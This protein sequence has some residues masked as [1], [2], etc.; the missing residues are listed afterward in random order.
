VRAPANPIIAGMHPDPSVCRARDGYYLACSSFEY[1]PGVPIHHSRDLV[2]WTL[3]GNALDRPAQLPLAGARSSGGIYAPTL[4]HHDGRFWLITTNVSA[5]GHVIYTAEDARGPW[6]DP[7]AVD[8][9][10][11]IDPDLAWDADG[12]CW[13]TYS[14]LGTAGFE[15]V[16]GAIKQV[17]L[18][19]VTG[20]VLESPRRLWSGTG[21]QFPEAP[22]L[23]EIDGTWYLLIA[24]GGTGPGHAVSIARGPSPAGPFEGCPHNPI[25]SHRSTDSPVQNTGHADLVQAPDGSWWM[26]LLGI[27]HAGAIPEVH[28][29]GRET[30]LAP[31]HWVEGWP[32]PTAVPTDVGR[33]DPPVRDDFESNALGPEWISVRTRPDSMWSLSERPGFLTL[34]ARADA[35]D[36]PEPAFVGRRQQHL[37]ARTRA[38]VDVS[39]GRGGLVV[40]MDEAHFYAIEAG[41]G[42]VRAHARVGPFSHATEPRP[43]RPS[44]VLRIDAVP[45]GTAR[46]PDVVRLGIE[47]DGDFAVLLELDGRYLSTEVA[48]GFTGR[49]IGMYA[50]DGSVAFDWFSY[51]GTD[52]D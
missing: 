43:S 40:R 28:V 19:P 14:E 34:H 33:D 45:D 32:A 15:A 12:T 44:T 51:E 30:F 5:R 6:S 4:R 48:G 38:A 26:V 35:M 50:V 29:L 8:G 36:A 17:R 39:G 20:R 37:Q 52:P 22:H 27:R 2:H 24:E 18:D 46:G 25:L 9:A 21:L 41:G 10:V 13:L 16:S 49:V 1:F 11:G 31:V 3:V 7:V 47:E 42:E 23:F